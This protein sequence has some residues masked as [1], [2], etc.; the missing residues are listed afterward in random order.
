MTRLLEALLRHPDVIDGQAA[1]VPTRAV[2]P[3]VTMGVGVFRDD[4]AVRIGHPVHDLRH[5]SLTRAGIEVPLTPPNDACSASSPRTPGDGDAPGAAPARRGPPGHRRH[6]A[7]RRA[8]RA[9]AQHPRSRPVR[10]HAHRHGPRP[11][12]PLRQTTRRT[13]A[14]RSRRRVCSCRSVSGGVPSPDARQ[15]H[16][17]A[18]PPRSPR[19]GC[20][21]V[22]VQPHDG[23][24]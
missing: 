12:P 14:C 19:T 10:T 2:V 18:V 6:E 13:A 8:H 20:A 7:A 23:G 1:V 4:I 3:R 22:S 11:R 24:A 17:G 21:P 9:L 16:A 5:G 15:G